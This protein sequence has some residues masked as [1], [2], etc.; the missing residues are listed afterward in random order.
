MGGGIRSKFKFPVPGRSSK[1]QQVPTVS[2]SSPPLSKAQRIL[3]ADGIN[4]GSSKLTVDPGR[5]WETGS[6]GAISISISESSASQPTNDIGFDREDDD[7]TSY[8]KDLWDQESAIIPRQIR[9]AHGPGRKGLTTKRSVFTVGNESR[10]NMT[11]TSTRGRRLSSS[12]IDT[13]YDSAK[14]PLAIS[15]QTSNSAMAKGLPSKVNVLLDMDGTLAGPQ[16]RKKK[17]ARLDFSRLRPKGHRDRNK[18][19]INLEPILGNNY[20]MSSP[21]FISQPLESP[22][23]SSSMTEGGQRTRRKLM[24]QHSALDSP[25]SMRSSPRSK[26]ITEP[27]GL[28]QLYHHYEQMSFR[29]EQTWEEEVDQEHIPAY[30][31][32][33]IDNQRPP[34]TFTHSL[35]APLP[36]PLLQGQGANWGHSRNNS[37]DSRVTA[38]IADSSGGLQVHSA[39]RKDYAGS[40]SSRHTRTSKASPSSKSIVESD[41]LQSS[42]LSLSD[43]SDDEA[44]ESASPAPLSH[45]ESLTH[46]V[47]SENPNPSR[48]QQSPNHPHGTTNSRKFIPSLNQLDEHLPVKSASNSQTTYSR[49]PSNN[50]LRSSHS[51]M[52]TLTPAHFLSP[53]APDSRLTS[54]STETLDTLGSSRQPSYGVQEATAVAFVPFAST[55]EAASKIS[56][57]G[58]ANPLEKA[59]LRQNSSATSRFSQSS[60]PISPSSVE[61]YMKSRESLQRDAMAGGSTE[62]QNAR[63]MAVTRQEEML[64]AA[65]RQKRAKMRETVISEAEEDGQSRTSSSRGSFVSSK[66][67]NTTSSKGVTGRMPIPEHNANLSN[68]S[69]LKRGSS[70]CTG[71]SQENLCE[72]A[73]Q[74]GSHKDL[75]DVDIPSAASRSDATEGTSTSATGSTNS[76]TFDSRNDR[77]LLYL[78]RPTQDIKAADRSQNFSDY[79]D[80]SDGE[81]LIVNERRTSR[82]QS[83]RDSAFGYRT[84]T[85]GSR[86]ESNNQDN[87][88][89]KNSIPIISPLSAPTKGRRLQDVPEV[90][91]QPEYNEDVDAD[92]TEDDVFDEFPQPPMPPPSWPLPPRPEKPAAKPDSPASSGFLHP[93]SASSAMHQG[94]S[95]ERKI[96]HLKS[97]RSLVRLS[98]V[99]HAHSPMPFWGDDD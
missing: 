7:D 25:R 66:K 97:K 81:D 20:V 45:R 37:H 33:G 59:L 92:D 60:D 53:S 91:P 87:Q 27:T 42:I 28:H 3:G 85:M 31:E 15:Q 50:T 24:K 71:V 30:P 57:S 18:N 93:S 54:R 29:D 96:G 22:M 26:G 10:D 83:R 58:N 72:V 98:A 19:V 5:S 90:E 46:G 77:V 38:S 52:S 68:K 51:S 99:G 16:P 48:G 55:V 11:N 34:S 89:R 64:L 32:R 6:T 1:K 39:S 41:R 82:M 23:L 70:L 9:S 47:V 95:P 78:D 49:S 79:M 56:I 17:P 94:H 88:Y 12:T 61:F 75:Q 63:L 8:G 13:H 65:L 36:L 76:T 86:R 73:R 67:S 21:S 74:N 80:D 4:T 62:A 69:R 14:M 84:D 40:V 44:I 2:V 43:S 35:I